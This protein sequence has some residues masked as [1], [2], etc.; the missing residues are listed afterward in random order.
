MKPAFLLPK[1][2]RLRLWSPASA[3][4]TTQDSR[5]MQLVSVAFKPKIAAQ[6]P[7]SQFGAA[8][9]NHAN[10]AAPD[11][12]TLSNTAAGYTTLG[13]KFAFAAVAGAATDYALFAYAVPSTHRLVLNGVS[14]STVNTGA[15]VTTSAHIFD[16]ALGINSTAVSLATTDSGST[17]GPRRIPLGLQA[18]LV[19][20]GIGAI[21]DDLVRKFDTPL[22]IE[23]SRYVHVILTMPVASATGSQVIRGAVTFDGYFE[24]VGEI[25][26]GL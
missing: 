4:N 1:R 17:Y 10:S 12:A 2:K 16:W 13:G 6:A 3:C 5:T 20:A 24:R 19:S 21:A 11:A 7:G 9:A 15:A 26:A 23:P 8:T 25:T 18:L 22:I 14:I